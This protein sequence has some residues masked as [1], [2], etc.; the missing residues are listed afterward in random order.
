MNEKGNKCSLRS[1]ILLLDGRKR[2]LLPVPT[3]S[4]VNNSAYG[5]LSY[6]STFVRQIEVLDLQLKQV[7]EI[8]DWMTGEK[9]FF[10]ET[11][12]RPF[13]PPKAACAV[14]SAIRREIIS[15]HTWK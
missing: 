11:S 9:I 6:E 13:L 15:N 3:A 7:D 8:N 5:R 4:P 12:G 10:L 2:H 1:F 14:E